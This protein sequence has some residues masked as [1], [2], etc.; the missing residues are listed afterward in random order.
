MLLKLNLSVY[1]VQ[2]NKS[3]QTDILY[4]LIFAHVKGIAFILA[5]MIFSTSIKASAFVGGMSN[6]FGGDM[7]SNSCCKSIDTSDLKECSDSEEE[8]EDEGCCEGEG[9]DCTCCLHIAYF[10]SFSQSN[11]KLNDFSDVKFGYSFLYQADYLTSVFH[12]PARK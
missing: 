4:C 8:K 7:T 5:L 11:G 12:P 10:Q 9:C 6:A 1:F 2:F 3:F